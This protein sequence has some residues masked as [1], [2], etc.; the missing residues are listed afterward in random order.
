MLD[1]AGPRTVLQRATTYGVFL[2]LSPPNSPGRREPLL[3]VTHLAAEGLRLGT[4]C[5]PGCAGTGTV[6]GPRTHQPGPALLSGPL[7]AAL[8]KDLRTEMP[9]SDDVRLPRSKDLACHPSASISAGCGEGR[10]LLM[11]ADAAGGPPRL[12][13]TCQDV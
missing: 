8:K 9:R 3:H 6:P 13:L 1:G 4:G 11:P 2:S 7:Y 10:T 5:P 12:T